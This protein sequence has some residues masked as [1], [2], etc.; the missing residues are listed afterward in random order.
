MVSVRVHDLLRIDPHAV[1]FDAEPQEWARAALAAVPWVVVRRERREGWIAVGVRGAT[2]AQ[3]SAGWVRTSAI[4]EVC[5]PESLAS[6]IPPRGFAAFDALAVAR[7]AAN[8]L[9]LAWGPVGAVG[10]ALA[11]GAP[12]VHVESDLDLVVRPAERWRLAQFAAALRDAPAR[13]DVIVE[14]DDGGVALTELLREA[15]P[16]L[17][18][19]ARGPQLVS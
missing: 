4:D 17:V 3:R 16:V 18:R 8:A 12:S 5:S 19:T 1:A 13:C 14:R 6:S 2:R 15:G 9:G 7:V 10:F 11:T